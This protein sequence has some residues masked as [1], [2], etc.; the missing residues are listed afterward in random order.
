MTAGKK[1][2]GLDGTA[3]YG[4]S[5][6]AQARQEDSTRISE[7][8]GTVF[9]P[10]LADDPSGAPGA[11]IISGEP[12]AG[13]PASAETDVQFGRFGRISLEAANPLLC[14]AAPLLLFLGDLAVIAPRGTLADLQRHLGEA[15]AVT[16]RKMTESGADTDDARIAKYLLCETAD[17]IVGNLPGIDRAT[18]LDDGM[19]ARFFRGKTAGTGFYEALN[20]VLA[21]PEAHCDLV[22][23]IHACLA[24][25]FQGQYRSRQDGRAAR[26]R[27]R[28]DVYETLRHFRPRPARQ[29]SPR[30]EGLGATMPR[31][32]RRVPLWVVAAAVPALLAGFFLAARGVIAER[33]NVAVEEL[34]K[35]NP[36]GP[37]I[38]HRTAFVAAAR[39][40]PAAKASPAPRDAQLDRI[41]NDL[42]A[43]LANGT[44]DVGT[45]GDFVVLELGDDTLFDPGTA[46]IKPAFGL[47]ARSL[48]GVL[49]KEAGPITIVGYADSRK[50]GITSAFR[51]S[52]DLSLARAKAM[53]DMLIRQIGDPARLRI[54]G[55]GGQDP[56]ADN[57]TAEGRAHNRRIDIL[58]RRERMP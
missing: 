1:S 21:S 22:E 58:I 47:L 11:V 52:Y 23:L 45:K 41:R 14:A 20:A 42:H 28:R 9:A 30:W 56:I 12:S 46:R 24:L 37:A 55:R 36:S 38:L 17:D 18:W 48:V 2:H 53:K 35:L 27:V 13:S 3:H 34:A 54:E 33:A 49:D 5:G 8:E 31:R 40:V 25:G 4:A 51:S 19:L 10:A 32:G 26:D 15:F 7:A 39:P 6:D 57:E 43:A 16:D 44:L 50:P 29:I